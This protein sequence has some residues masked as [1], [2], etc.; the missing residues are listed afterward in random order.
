MTGLS[1]KLRGQVIP[2]FLK[3]QQTLPDE[4]FQPFLQSCADFSAPNRLGNTERLRRG[5]GGCWEL[6]SAVLSS[7]FARVQFAGH[8]PTELAGAAATRLGLPTVLRF[9]RFRVMGISLSAI[10]LQVRRETAQIAKGWPFSVPA[11]RGRALSVSAIINEMRVFPQPLATT[12][13]AE[14]RDLGLK[15]RKVVRHP[16]TT[17][18]RS[19]VC[20]VSLFAHDQ[21]TRRTLLIVTGIQKSA[22][23]EIDQAS[24]GQS[25]G[26]PLRATLSDSVPQIERGRRSC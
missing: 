9:A 24:E 3:T 10:G 6:G 2:K 17:P 8:C 19:R 23:A 15:T 20:G 16:R 7:F 4:H 12:D 26:R 18:L 21:G 25:C 1:R 11:S 5:L 14:T 13:N 22:T